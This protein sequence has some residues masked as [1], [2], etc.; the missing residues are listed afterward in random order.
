MLK[1]TLLVGGSVALVLALLFGTAIVPYAKS[2]WRNVQESV[3][4]AIPI[5]AQID[6]A[7]EQIRDIGPEIRDMVAKV[8]QEKVAIGGLEKEIEGLAA[9]VKDEEA[10][11]VSLRNHLKTDE[12]HYVS[13]GRAFTN[14]QVRNDLQKRFDRLKSTQGRLASMQQVLDAR[15]SALDA[16][17]AKLDETK[18]Q[19]HELEVIV[20]ELEARMRVVEVQQQANHLSLDTSQLSAARNMMN[21]IRARIEAAEQ[22]ASLMPK[23]LGEIPVETSEASEDIESQIDAYFGQNDE[24]NTS[25]VSG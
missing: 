21:D 14:D 11:I 10:K 24:E 25:R 13:K 22:E 1:K 8:A 18:A 4:Q 15:L 7:R 16:A 20:E 2:S 12:Q 9:Q 6:A 23:Y 3:Q 17:M 5:H 19:R